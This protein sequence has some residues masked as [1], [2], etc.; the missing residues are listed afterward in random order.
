MLIGYLQV[1]LC[2]IKVF[3]LFYI[4]MVWYD[5][6]ASV[7]VCIHLQY[8]YCNVL[9]SFTVHSVFDF[10]SVLNAGLTVIENDISCRAYL[11]CEKCL[12]EVCKGLGVI[13]LLLIRL[14]GRD[15]L[16]RIFWYIS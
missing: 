7:F 9:Y 10:Q 2:L 11:S 8:I 5:E 6:Q 1:S 14:V 3:F 12:T 15:A 16:I 13:G 4:D